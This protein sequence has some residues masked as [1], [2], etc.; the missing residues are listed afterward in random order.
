VKEIVIAR[1]ATILA[2]RIPEKEELINR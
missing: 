2:S 1:T